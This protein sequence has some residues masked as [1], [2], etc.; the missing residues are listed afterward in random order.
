MRLG[1]EKGVSRSIAEQFPVF[2]S[3]SIGIGRIFCGLVLDLKIKNKI[4][5]MQFCMMLVGLNCFL[6]LLAETQ[7]HFIAFVWIF[8]ALDG[9]VLTTVAPALRATI[10]CDFLSEGYSLVLTADAIALL[11]G[12]PFVGKLLHI[13]VCML[14]LHVCFIVFDEHREVMSLSQETFLSFN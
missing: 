10:G 3:I 1:I 11:V 6:G 14:A 9:I 5:F 2:T 13:E 8:G 12:P 4:L 7:A